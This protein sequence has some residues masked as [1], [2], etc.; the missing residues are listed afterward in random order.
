LSYSKRISR[1][2]YNDLASFISYNDPVSVFTGNPLLKPTITNNL[3]LGLNY[4]DY[5]FS[6]LLSKDDYPIVQ[7][8]LTKSPS[9]NYLYVSPQ[10]LISRKNLTI[11]TNLPGKVGSWWTMNYGLEGG[12]KQ[13]R[14]D[15]T[16]EP[17]DK[18]YFFYSLNFRQSFKLPKN[19]LVE[20]SG[21]YNSMNYYGTIKIG[22]SGSVNGGIKKD[23]K[24]NKG[25]LQLSVS[26]IFKTMKFNNYFGALTT[27][28]FNVKNHVRINT[29]SSHTQIVKL[30]YSR[31][32]GSGNA[33]S[34]G[35]QAIGSQDEM[36]RV[37]SN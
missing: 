34:R 36:E 30:T 24:G 13:F 33:K 3:K 1:P 31:S 22:G 28:A 26:D 11:Q 16:L 7:S 10:N 9:G 14:E 8:Q 27:E 20:L 2:T 18:T 23:L 21:W 25:S 5:S 37:R 32:F 6:L 4:R 35:S 19:F 29:E 17:V 15:Y 12:W